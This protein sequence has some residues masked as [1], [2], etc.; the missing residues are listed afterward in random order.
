MA[1][2][3]FKIF[4]NKKIIIGVIHFSPLFGYSNSPGFKTALNNA[5][6]DLKAF[7]NGG[8]D[9]IIIENNYDI[10]H[11]II[12]R[13]GTI[14][15]ITRLGIEIKK[16]TK[17]PIGVSVL[18]NDFKAAFLIAKKIGAKFIRI[19]VFIDK[20]K[21]NYGIITG[22]PE[23]V[24]NY[25]K[26]IK[27]GNVAI[28][29]DIQVKHSIILNKKTI[30]ESALEA[31]REGS[32]A[33]IITGKWTGQAPNFKKLITVRNTIPNFPILIGSGVNKKN[34]NGLL[35]YAN[36]IIVST[37]LKKGVVKKGEINLKSWKQRVD[38]KK[39]KEL[40]KNAGRKRKSP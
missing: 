25:R 10:P 32:D 7:E 38:V 33:L 13:P 36:G 2:K 28:F 12:V 39:V 9:A 16:A 22:N 11:K 5:L 37:S 14:N 23:K 19:P 24:L 34:I 18:W 31:V 40:I 30:K 21:T 3:F 17:L 4:K 35:K 8:V 29:T 27:A 1:S 6:K 20:V 15:I 26:R